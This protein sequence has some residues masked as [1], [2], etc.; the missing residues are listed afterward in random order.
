MTRFRQL[1]DEIAGRLQQVPSGDSWLKE[2]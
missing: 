2:Q 1:V